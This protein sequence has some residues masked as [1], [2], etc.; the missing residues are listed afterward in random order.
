MVEFD[1]TQLKH[2]TMVRVEIE[3]NPPAGALGKAVAKLFG[4]EPGQQ[5][6]GDLRRFKQVMETGEVVVS[7]ATIRGNSAYDQRP[8]QPPQSNGSRVY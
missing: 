3:Y 5:V 7:D 4:E 2:G 1:D 8:A 6:Q